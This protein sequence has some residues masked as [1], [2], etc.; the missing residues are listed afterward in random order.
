MTV[1]LN[2]YK[3]FVECVTSSASENLETLI[4]TMRILQT[5]EPPLNVS[6][7]LTASIG[8]ASEGGEFSE[9]VKKMIFQGKPWNEETRHHMFREKVKL[10]LMLILQPAAAP[11]E[12][13]WAA[14]QRNEFNPLSALYRSS[15]KVHWD[16]DLN[17]PGVQLHVR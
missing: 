11:F 4:S 17:I 9:L 1:D 8:L 13:M 6:L 12:W 15:S 14:C 2:R 7:L 3:D 10:T 5:Q 16:L